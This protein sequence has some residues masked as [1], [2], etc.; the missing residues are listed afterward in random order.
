MAKVIN[1]VGKSGE[2]W[3]KIYTF[4]FIQSHNGKFN[5][6]MEDDL[7]GK[8]GDGYTENIDEFRAFKK[9]SK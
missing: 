3:E 2:M 1:K 5:W 8:H 6:R 7:T 9:V 4:E